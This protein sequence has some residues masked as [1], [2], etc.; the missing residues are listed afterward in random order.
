MPKKR[1]KSVS[2]R[3]RSA[4]PKKT[5]FGPDRPRDIIYSGSAGGL[6]RRKRMK[7]RPELGR[8]K[9]KSRAKPRGKTITKYL[10]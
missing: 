3:K 6:L 10:D 5:P 4:K 1:K 8:K 2:K 9:S 7:K